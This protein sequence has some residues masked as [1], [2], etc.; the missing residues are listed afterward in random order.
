[1]AIIEAIEF[2][3]GFY[4]IFIVG[5]WDNIIGKGG[6]GLIILNPEGEFV[7]TRAMPISC[8]IFIN[9]AE[10]IAIQEGLLIAKELQNFSEENGERRGSDDEDDTWTEIRWETTPGRRAGG[11]RRLEWT[12]GWR[13][14]TPGRRA[15]GRRRLEWTEGWRETTPGVDGG[16]KGGWN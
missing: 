10:A 2:Q 15:G 11:R 4:R 1:M 14:M 7:A 8:I 9:V 3:P 12:E 13:E 6:I 5:A 16:L